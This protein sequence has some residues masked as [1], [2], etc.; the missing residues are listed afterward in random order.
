MS[1]EEKLKKLG[2]VLPSPMK[3]VGAYRSCVE[4]NGMVY[5]AGQ[6]PVRPDGTLVTGRV[7]DVRSEEEAVEAARLT[8]LNSLSQLRAH[9]G[10]LDRIKEIVRVFGLVNAVPGFQNHPKVIDGFSQLMVEVFGDAGKGARC[11]VGASS[12]PLDI[13]VEVEM[14]VLV[15]D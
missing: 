8:A 3:P 9:L 1:V 10:S 15:K 14:S 6:G 5:V 4:V 11:A 2:I 12:L 7:P 13:T